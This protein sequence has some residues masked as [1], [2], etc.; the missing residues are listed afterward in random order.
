MCAQI[1]KVELITFHVCQHAIQIQLVHCHLFCF[2]L[3]L[4]CE[5]QEDE[6]Y[7]SS[8]VHGICILM[9]TLFFAAETD[10][11]QSRPN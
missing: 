3:S 2:N 4:T 11:I 5:C 7:H 10:R 6:L 1:V 9:L 8:H